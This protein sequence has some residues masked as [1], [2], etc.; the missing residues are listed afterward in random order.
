MVIQ[1]GI[2]D[3][4]GYFTH[5]Y[6]ILTTHIE[7]FILG[8]IFCLMQYLSYALDILILKMF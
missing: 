7:Y 4:S 6:E 8:K 1:I 3:E 5:I 2:I